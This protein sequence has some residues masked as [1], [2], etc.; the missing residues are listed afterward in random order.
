M[1][2]FTSAELHD[3][4]M[5]HLQQGIPSI[6]YS[7]TLPEPRFIG[8]QSARI[9]HRFSTKKRKQTKEKEKA[10][11]TKG[12]KLQSLDFA[13]SGYCSPICKTL[14]CRLPA[15][16]HT[17]RLVE[18]IAHLVPRFLTKTQENHLTTV[19]T[20]SPRNRQLLLMK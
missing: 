1:A 11:G 4:L 16:F 5:E 12:T 20:H 19:L 6:C 15:L 14:T 8:L 9:R 13:A 17:V 18:S 2:S 10:C 3:L 7:G